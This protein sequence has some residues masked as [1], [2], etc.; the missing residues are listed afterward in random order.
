[1]VAQHR[2]RI[3]TEENAKVV[4]ASW[5]TELLQFLAELAILQ[6]DELKNRLICPLQYS[7]TRPDTLTLT[8]Q[9]NITY[10]SKTSPIL[11]IYLA[12]VVLAE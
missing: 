1:M 6:E 12:L 11:V 5:G 10:S 9:I 3:Y 2:R 8:L 4:A 7:S